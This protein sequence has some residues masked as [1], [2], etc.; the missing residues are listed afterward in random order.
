MNN[1]TGKETNM[2]PLAEA[3]HF[4]RAFFTHGS[5]Y[6]MLLGA[7]YECATLQSILP[8]LLCPS[9]MRTHY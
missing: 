7:V 3:Q 2:P 5:G 1:P 6:S 8:R 4:A 9:Y